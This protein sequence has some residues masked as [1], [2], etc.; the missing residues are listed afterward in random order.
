MNNYIRH[1]QHTPLLSVSLSLKSSEK[2]KT[3]STDFLEAHYTYLGLT[4]DVSPDVERQYSVPLDLERCSVQ[5]GG[6]TDD[7]AES[8]N[9]EEE[10][11]GPKEEEDFG[12]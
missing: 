5:P 11:R 8:D 7:E 10:G 2:K 12:G 9:P 6:S 1:H 3:C 4:H